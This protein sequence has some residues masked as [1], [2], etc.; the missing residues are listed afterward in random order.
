MSKTAFSEVEEVLKKRIKSIDYSAFNSECIGD[1]LM[2]FS[3]CFG[4]CCSLY[5]GITHQ[6]AEVLKGL[7][8]AKKEALTQI[9]V[10]LTSDVRVYDCEID[11]YYLAKRRRKF[12]QLAGIIHT[13]IRRAKGRYPINFK[14]FKDFSHCCVFSLKDGSCALQ[15]LAVTEG[16]HPWFYKPINCWKY[17]LSIDNGNVLTV[18]KKESNCCFPCNQES[19]CEKPA[20]EALEKEIIFLGQII[21]RDLLGEIR[22]RSSL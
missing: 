6:E 17:P 19:E 7:T 11:R 13:L 10:K 20:I 15:H 14:L 9:G 3:Q 16:R 21:E 5:V 18:F 4:M 12:F 1:C 22:K 8:I 2:F